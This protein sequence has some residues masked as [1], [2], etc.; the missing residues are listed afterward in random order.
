MTVRMPMAVVVVIVPV[1]MPVAVVVRVAEDERADDIDHKADHR[2]RDRLLVADRR[3]REQP[4]D[5][6]ERHQGDDAQQEDRARETPEDL[7]LPRAEGEAPVTGVAPCGRIG[8]RTTPIATPCE[9]MCR[10]SASSAIEPYARPAA[11]SMAIAASVIQVTSSVPRC[12]A[13]LPSSKRWSCCQRPR[14][15]VCMVLGSRP[16]RITG[17]G[18]VIDGVGAGEKSRTPDLR[19]T[20]ALLYQ[21]SYAGVCRGRAAANAGF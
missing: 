14:S 5:R 3:R 7:D 6:A 9:L 8:E 11:T 21:L 17:D 12:P 10:P 20:N 4:F 1:L 15:W 2:D 16:G 19:I 13:A 18:A